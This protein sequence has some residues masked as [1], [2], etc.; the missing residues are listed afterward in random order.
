MPI[1]NIQKFVLVLLY[2]SLVLQS[3]ILL[4]NPMNVNKKAN[5]AF[6]IFMLLWSG[7]WVL[8][9]LKICGFSPGPLLIFSV[10]SVL[11]FTPLFLF[12]SVVVF[13]NPNYYFKKKDLICLVIPFIYLVLL[14]NADENKLLNTITLLIA[15][16]HNLPYVA[17]IYYKIR[18]HQKRIE[19]ISSDTESINLQWL[20]KLS[21]L[22]FG[23]III[24]VCYELFNAF[25]YKMHQNLIM[26]LLFLFI[27]Y[28]TF[29]HVLRQKE[30]YP[31][32]KVQLEELLSIE[33]ESEEK[34]EK[35][36]LIPDEDFEDLKEKLLTL[37]ESQK[38]Y[39][40]GDLNLL[41]LS[42]LI[43]I[44]THQLSYLLNNGFNENFFQFVNKY[45]VQHAKELLISDSYNKL[46]VLGIA[47]DS[48]FNSKTA[49]NTFFKKTVGV[50]PSEFR[51]NQSEGNFTEEEK[52][53]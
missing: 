28:S 41:K 34:T 13:I 47:F 36:K 7:Y 15:V 26:D 42:E 29:Y 8:D 39:L 1:E 20:I 51:K 31:V 14:L 33:T 3:F 10:Y 37:I 32:S 17:I 53:N 49:F 4:A 38:P 16:A 2:G 25:V 43:G 46:S 44:S 9:I 45:R 52:L 6:G 35:K 48:G 11:I 23:T 24:T 12:F 30:I 22:L 40:E 21:L 5:F 18:K 19:T 27:V 50:T